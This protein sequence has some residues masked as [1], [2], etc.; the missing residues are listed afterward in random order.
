MAYISTYYKGSSQWIEPA[1][2]NALVGGFNVQYYLSIC[3]YMIL[4]WKGTLNINKQRAGIFKLVS[5][6]ISCS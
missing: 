2:L 6:M 5:Q 1:C 4:R 3:E